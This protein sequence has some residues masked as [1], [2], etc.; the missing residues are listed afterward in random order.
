ML[1][2]RVRS[3]FLNMGKPQSMVKLQLEPLLM[4]NLL[5]LLP[6]MVK[7]LPTVKHLLMVKH[8]PMGKHLLMGNLTPN[9]LPR[10]PV[11]DSLKATK[12]QSLLPLLLLPSLLQCLLLPPLQLLLLV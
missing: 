4:V 12:H 3:S 7:H 6:L 11:M 2:Q 9:I 1:V 5:S 8:Q 10:K